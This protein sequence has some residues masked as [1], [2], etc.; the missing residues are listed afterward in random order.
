MLKKENRIRNKNNN[1]IIIMTMI[2]MIIFLL[3][4]ILYN[5]NSDILSSTSKMSTK[6]SIKSYLS[7]YDINC[8]LSDVD[9]TLLNSDHKI[10][11][12]TYDAIY[13]AISSGELKFFP[14]TGRSR[15]SM[16]LAT[17]DRFMKLFGNHPPGVYLHIKIQY[18]ML[19]GL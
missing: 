12:K 1:N 11:D 9:G 14:C 4:I 3:L 10:G 18:Q 2:P 17:G 15:Y 6:S 13:N 7:N 5:G 19:S 16:Q 8:I